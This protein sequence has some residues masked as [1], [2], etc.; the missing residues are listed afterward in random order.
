MNDFP[1]GSLA[2]VKIV[3]W[4]DNHN[5]TRQYITAKDNYDATWHSFLIIG[6]NKQIRN[7]LLSNSSVAGDPFFKDDLKIYEIDPIYLGSKVAMIY[8]DYLE[9]LGRVCQLCQ[10]HFDYLNAE[11]EFICWKCET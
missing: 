7:L 5:N 4:T 6:R 9:Y 8:V 10:N 11:T 1:I 2:W 3:D